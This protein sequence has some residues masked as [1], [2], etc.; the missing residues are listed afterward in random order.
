MKLKPLCRVRVR[1]AR[2]RYLL[3][4]STRQSPPNDV[5]QVFRHT[6]ED[7]KPS[8]GISAGKHLTMSVFD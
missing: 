6:V 4:T 8:E 1:G 5:A 7:G 2:L 3:S